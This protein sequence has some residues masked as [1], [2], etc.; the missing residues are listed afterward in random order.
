MARELD[1]YF[2]FMSPPTYL[3]YTQM[4]GLISRTGCTVNYKPMFTIG[5]HQLTGNRSPREVP[6]KAAWLGGDLRR[7]ARRYGVTLGSNSHIDTLKIIPPLRGVFVAR[8]RGET[9][10]YIAAMF[11]GMWVEDANIGE[12]Q[13]FARLTAEAGL[14]PAAYAVGIERAD[15]KEALRAG[16]QE[17]ADRGA[18]GAPSFFVNGELFWGQDRL[19]FVEDALREQPP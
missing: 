14:D 15:V 6:N 11:R 19:E 4:P 9:D 17:A 7:W 3:A 10:A 2:D 18:F 16:T 5:L 1:F 13:T 8:D 12:A